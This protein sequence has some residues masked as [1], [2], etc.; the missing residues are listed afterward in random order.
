VSADTAWS[1]LSEASQRLMSEEISTADFSDTLVRIIHNQCEH[2]VLAMGAE[3]GTISEPTKRSLLKYSFESMFF[4]QAEHALGQ[5]TPFSA[6]EPIREKLLEDLQDVEKVCASV[7]ANLKTGAAALSMPVGLIRRSGQLLSSL[8]G[9]DQALSSIASLLKE[10]ADALATKIKGIIDKS[11][12]THIINEVNERPLHVDLA[13]FCSSI[14]RVFKVC[15]EYLF[16][17]LNSFLL[18]FSYL[19]SCQKYVF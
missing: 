11:N 19:A 17:N 4:F 2:V 5:F 15:Q 3:V 13:L 16:Q 12:A 6:P 10:R 7:A 14:K 9:G 1:Q 8:S 18:H